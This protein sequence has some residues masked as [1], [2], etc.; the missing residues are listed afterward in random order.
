MNTILVKLIS[1]DF[2][3]KSF[4]LIS[5][6]SLFYALFLISHYTLSQGASP[7]Y[8]YFLLEYRKGIPVIYSIFY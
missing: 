4:H 7:K 1:K 3:S 2:S 8:I 6:P 5:Q